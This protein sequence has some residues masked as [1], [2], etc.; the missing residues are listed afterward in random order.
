MK[1][2]G[3]YLC[4]AI[5]FSFWFSVIHK[6]GNHAI[7]ELFGK[8]KIMFLDQMLYKYLSKGTFECEFVEFLYASVAT[9]LVTSFSNHVHQYVIACL[10]VTKHLFP[11]TW[12]MSKIS[13]N[14]KSPSTSYLFTQRIAS[15]LS[16]IESGHS[17]KGVAL[18]DFWILSSVIYLLIIIEM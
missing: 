7:V 2:L 13:V 11:S 9:L 15:C 5:L 3:N 17:I 14:T 8:A 12:R 6:F 16:L 1:A 4:P 18:C 10:H